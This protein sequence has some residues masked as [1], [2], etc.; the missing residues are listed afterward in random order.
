MNTNIGMK[1]KVNWREVGLFVGITFIVSWSV[2]L[3]LKLTVGY[4]ENLGTLNSLQTQ[5]LIPAF[6]ALLL[7]M[8]V[9]KSSP[10]YFRTNKAA[11][12]WF[13]YSFLLFTL[14]FAGF[15]VL[16][17]A[18]PQI[19]AG[20]ESLKLLLYVV[21]ITLAL[22]TGLK[23]A[24]ADRA[25]LGFSG[26]SFIHWLVVFLAFTLYIAFSAGMNVLLG[27]SQPADLAVLM[28]QVGI[29]SPSLLVAL[30]IL[31][32][33]L[34]MS[35]LSLVLAFGEEYGWRY[36][37]QNELVKLGKI[38]GIFLVGLIWA[39]WHYPAIWMGHNYPGQPVLGTL[40]F[41]IFCVLASFIFGYIVL[42]TGSIW[43]AAF[44]HAVNNQVFS[45]MMFLFGT[46]E[47]MVLSFGSGIYGL[48]VMA[49]IVALILR[50]PVWKGAPVIVTDRIGSSE[51][52]MGD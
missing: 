15:T 14:V 22:V 21:M 24:R 40:M 39:A 7:G 29:P 36:Y 8:F 45:T 49:V 17:I 16:S 2:N 12:R 18:A 4:G 52:V 33:G 26:G 25:A 27:L 9:F 34:I 42:K 20:L 44:A 37:L 6:V 23:T 50:D 41:T 3:I 19:M 30:T 47:N 13:F 28:E 10:L 51:A 31:Q 38:R 11:A 46:P 48:T 5:M 43:L 1:S 32:S 35:L